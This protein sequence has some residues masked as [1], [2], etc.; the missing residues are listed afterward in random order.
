MSN[1][2]LPITSLLL[3]ITAL[4]IHIPICGKSFSYHYHYVSHLELVTALMDTRLQALERNISM[5]EKMRIRP[6]S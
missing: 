6:P 2:Q 3:N 5:S 1:R 4:N